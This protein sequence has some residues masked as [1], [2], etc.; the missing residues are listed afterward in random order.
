MTHAFKWIFI[1]SS[2][3][4]SCAAGARDIYVDNQNANANDSNAGTAT[5]PLRTL[6]AGVAQANPGDV[7]IVK[8]GRYSDPNSTWYSAFTPARSGTQAAPITIRSEPK[9]AAVLVPR[10][11]QTGSRQST[12]PALSIYQKQY[13]V[14]DGFKAEGMMKIHHDVMGTGQYVTIQNCEI[15]YG[16]QQGDDPSLNWGLAIHVS[17]NNVLRNNRIFNMRSSGNNSENTGA[18]MNFASAYNLIENN[19]ADAGNGIVYSAF[20]QKA[21]N[22]HDNV[23]RRNIARNAVAGFEG[24][25]GTG[26]D[27]FCDNETFYN[28]IIINTE[29]AFSLN[30]NSRHWKVYNNTAYNVKFLLNQWQLNSLDNQ[31]W[32]NL[33]VSAGSSVYQIEDLTTS[34]FAPYISYSNYNFLM[35]APSAFARWAYGGSTLSLAQWRTTTGMDANTL[36]GDALFVNAAGNNFKLQSGSPAIGRGRNAENIGAYATGN[37]VIGVNLGPRPNPPVLAVN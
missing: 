10:D 24:K 29:R 30:H 35:S 33:V 25:G 16:S 5:A 26:G 28:N 20:G 34:N 37:E 2:L 13:I 22:I 1:C 17:N 11:F 15:Q 3:M 31:F 14:I 7:V 8:A 4:L 32:N 21:G 12:M 6:T 23:W 27:S 18:V 19:D 36:T 9:L